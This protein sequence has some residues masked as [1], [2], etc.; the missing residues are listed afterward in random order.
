MTAGSKGKDNKN[1]SDDKKE[2]ITDTK[3][4]S[5]KDEPSAKPAEDKDGKKDAAKPAAK[6]SR[7]K[8]PSVSKSPATTD[9]AAK[10]KTDDKTD[11]TKADA[12]KNKSSAPAGV[13]TDKTTSPK[14]TTN[15]QAKT[16]G[17]SLPPQPQAKKS[18]GAS[19]VWLILILGIIGG[20]AY[21]TLPL[22]KGY[23]SPEWQ[24]K[25]DNLGG[26]KKAGQAPSGPAGDQTASNT[27][28]NTTPE[29]PAVNQTL[30]DRID[31][32]EQELKTVRAASGDADA[33][34]DLKA[35]REAI[36]QQLGDLIGRLNSLEKQIGN[37]QQIADA[38]TSQQEAFAANES[39]N[40]LS[41]RLSHLESNSEALDALMARIAKLEEQ[42]G[43]PTAGAQALVL[44]VGQLREALRG[45]S[46]FVQ[47]LD[48]LKA[49]APEE[50]AIT[51]A[52]ANLSRYAPAG[53]LTM[54]TLR[55]QFD[56]VASTIVAADSAMKGE[57]W[58][59]TTVNR[60]KGLVSIRRTDGAPGGSAEALVA[61]A[62]AKLEQ[63][64][65]QGA[66][67]SLE[68]LSDTARKAAS[69]WLTA[70]KARLAVE[71]AM[72]TLHVHSVSLL[73]PAKG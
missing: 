60:L 20:G 59:D 10:P 56:D 57:G 3:T 61:D 1:A 45:S 18:G 64:D 6:N 8:P 9:P 36:N 15:P 48:S 43:N 25:L 29:A 46:P 69:G 31:M 34:K 44:A 27:A 5:P 19:L 50:G 16:H 54:D 63:G 72:A 65:L 35:E 22:W 62:D 52:L 11:N 67:K 17:G 58:M 53:V 68:G 14:S 66:L 47:E 21:A 49:I 26:I 38:T 73:A 32:L 51:E 2:G 7:T 33:L 28:D 23:L 55:Q 24:T 41:S 42:G 40:N 39:L 13:N 30:L 37:V 12:D 71:K 70:A 4:P